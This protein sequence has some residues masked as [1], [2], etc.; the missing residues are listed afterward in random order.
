MNRKL[1]QIVTVCLA[2]YLA[3]LFMIVVPNHHH[4][5]QAVHDDCIICVLAH[6][7]LLTAVEFSLA[8]LTMMVFIN[9]CLFRNSVPF[10]CFSAFLSRAP[11]L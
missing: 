4:E 3:M 11:P 7:P 6:Q 1:K 10:I 9:E 8:L 2:L 5:D